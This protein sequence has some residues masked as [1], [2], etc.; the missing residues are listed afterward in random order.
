MQCF[1]TFKNIR[2]CQRG[3]ASKAIDYCNIAVVSRD[4]SRW[5]TSRAIM[6][7][8][9]ELVNTFVR[10]E[11]HLICRHPATSYTGLMRPVS[12]NATES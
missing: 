2:D 6:L 10:A 4:L 1:Y 5:R 3:N 8:G 7:C 9:K 12:M 11:M